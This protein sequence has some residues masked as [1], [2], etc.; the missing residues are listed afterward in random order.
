MNRSCTTFERADVGSKAVRF[1]LKPIVFFTLFVFVSVSHSYG[2]NWGQ[3]EITVVA[4][5]PALSTIFSELLPLRIDPGGRV[6]GDLLIQSV[7][8]LRFDNNKV[9]CSIRLLGKKAK[10]TMPLQKAASVVVDIGDLDVSFDL[11]GALRFDHGAHRLYVKPTIV[12]DVRGAAEG[13]PL[14]L[15]LSLL[16]QIE[17]PIHMQKLVPVMT[18]TGDTPVQLDLSISDVSSEK[19]RLLLTV[20][21]RVVKAE[22]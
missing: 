21:P 7:Q 6:S 4:P 12:G 2:G 10:Y 17:Y 3:D 20:Q 16:T 1:G 19:N 13:S 15:L 18:G 22:P 14:R 9:L 5:G 11:E 8:N